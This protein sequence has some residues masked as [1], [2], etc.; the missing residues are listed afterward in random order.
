MIEVLETGHQRFGE[1][2]YLLRVDNEDADDVEISEHG[3]RYGLQVLLRD[4]RLS[5]QVAKHRFSEIP[6]RIKLLQLKTAYSFFGRK[7]MYQE[8]NVSMVAPREFSL[9]SVINFDTAEW[10]EPFSIADYIDEFYNHLELS[11]QRFQKI[12]GFYSSLALIYYVEDPQRT[13]EAE[14]LMHQESI[15][16]LHGQVVA[17][18]TTSFQDESVSVFFDFPEEVKVPC[19]Q[20]LLYFGQFLKDLGVEADTS[21]THDAGQVL[22]TVTPADK[23]EA[24]DKIRSALNLYLQLP[25]SPVS[26]TTNE[27]VEVQ[28]LEVSILRLK[29]DLKLAAAEAQARD[30]TI[31]AQ[32]IILSVQN[33]LLS[34]E[35]LVKSINDVTPKPEDKEDLIGGLVALS[36][37]KEKGVEVNL[38]EILRRMK[39]LFGKK[40]D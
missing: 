17:S 6:E 39:R 25:S 35:I 24:L 2:G 22:F 31:K 38:G 7:A 9:H 4:R 40:D 19:E 29:S 28:K 37:Y 13:I 27:S 10:K 5:Q 15:R 36:T 26:D 33:A 14:F 20:Y 16:K 30:A 3:V 11:N 23:S 12:D 32:Q 21:L 8:V 1:K 34:G 18:L